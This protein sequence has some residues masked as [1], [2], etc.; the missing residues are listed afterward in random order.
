MYAMLLGNE[1]AFVGVELFLLLIGMHGAC[2]EGLCVLSSTSSNFVTSK[3]LYNNSPVSDSSIDVVVD[4]KYSGYFKSNSSGY[5]SFFAPFSIGKNYITFQYNGHSSTFVFYYFDGLID[6]LAIPTSII[7]FLALYR[8]SNMRAANT[9]IELYIDQNGY[10]KLAK[11][12]FNKNA[13]LTN[14]EP[15]IEI[16]Y[17]AA[18]RKSLLDGSFKISRLGK[19]QTIQKNNIISISQIGRCLSKPNR[20]YYLVPLHI[21]EKGEFFHLMQSPTKNGSKLLYMHTIGLIEVLK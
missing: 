8:F 19:L 16:A 9:P 4:G 21:R 11:N 1:G 17:N 7:T 20:Q 5:I 6:L 13:T 18:L 15:Y 3:I 14:Y 12:R 10:E 2:P